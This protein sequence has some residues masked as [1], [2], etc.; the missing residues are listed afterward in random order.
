M[1]AGETLDIILETTATNLFRGNKIAAVS[2][3]HVNK[4]QWLGFLTMAF[5]ASNTSAGPIGTISSVSDG[6]VIACTAGFLVS[7][8]K[9]FDLQFVVWELIYYCG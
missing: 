9:W 4:I 3:M 7:I 1:A 8:I 2:V 5:D 6:Q